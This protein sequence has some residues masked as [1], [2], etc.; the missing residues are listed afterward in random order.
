MI[1]L[2]AILA[3]IV[4]LQQMSGHRS[5]FCPAQYACSGTEWHKTT[6]LLKCATISFTHDNK[7]VTNRRNPKL[8][9]KQRIAASKYW[10]FLQSL[11]V[12]P[13]HKSVALEIVFCY[14]EETVSVGTFHFAL[15]SVGRL[16]YGWNAIKQFRVPIFHR[17]ER[18]Q[19]YQAAVVSS[20]FNMESLNTSSKFSCSCICKNT[21]APFVS[22]FSYCIYHLDQSKLEAVR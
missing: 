19:I 11:P 8:Q 6:S 21:A 5:V 2:S 18:A 3:R 13:V 22:L 9:T 16:L 1:L 20:R 12:T 4:W 15:F 14:S 17:T 10:Q 7:A